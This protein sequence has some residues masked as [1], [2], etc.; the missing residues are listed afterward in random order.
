MQKETI[1]YI[2][3]EIERALGMKPNEHFRIIS[4]RTEYG[5]KI[6]KE[7]PRFVTLIKEDGKDS[8]GTGDL[9]KHPDTRRTIDEITAEKNSKPYVMVFKNTI[10]I[11]PIAK[12]FGWTL[13]NP[14]A[15]ASEKVENKISQIRWL[16]ELEHYLPSHRIEYM[17]NVKFADK[18]FIIQWAHGHTGGGTIL[19]DNENALNDLKVRFP[20]RRAR[21]TQYIDGPSF[22]VNVIVTPD[23]IIQ[24]NPSYQITGMKPFTDSVFSTIGNDWGFAHKTLSQQDIIWLNDIITAL[25]KKMQKEFWKGLFGIDVIKDMSTGKLYLIEVNARQPASTT[26]ESNMQEALRA[27]GNTGITTMEAHTDALLGKPVTGELIRINDGSQIIQRV[28]KDKSAVD[29]SVISSLSQIG[30]NV[31]NYE[32]KD[33][34]SDLLRIQSKTSIIEEHNK[35][36]DLGQKISNILS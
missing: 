22:T 10:R 23:R 21:V 34:N 17:K 8:S 9:M 20:E 4:N 31:I 19:I 6:R 29:K 24:S 36:N 5:E 33:F 27:S 1:V 25:G 35:L 28:T 11:E 32:N 13:I 3:R 2:T 7:F 26:Y 16:G 30:L 15:E 14:L 12:E 18:P